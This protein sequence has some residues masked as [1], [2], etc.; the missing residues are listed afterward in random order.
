MNY[1]SD[2]KFL[3]N[4]APKYSKNVMLVSLKKYKLLFNY[5]KNS[6]AM[7]TALFSGVTGVPKCM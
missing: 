2:G 1:D 3:C 4:G 7:C 5:S 6:S